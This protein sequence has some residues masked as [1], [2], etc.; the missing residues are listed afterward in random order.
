MRNRRDY[1]GSDCFTVLAV[2][3]LACTFSQRN[4][5][6]RKFQDFD[7]PPIVLFSI[8][9]SDARGSQS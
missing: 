6:R 3:P 8:Q 5:N 4:E 9:I 7:T 1:I 2:A